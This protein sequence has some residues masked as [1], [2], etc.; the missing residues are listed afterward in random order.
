VTEVGRPFQMCAAATESAW[1]PT[2]AGRQHVKLRSRARPQPMSGLDV[3][4]AMQVSRCM[5]APDRADVDIP[6]QQV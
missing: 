3:S 1:S 5:A 4:Q 6:E 2:A